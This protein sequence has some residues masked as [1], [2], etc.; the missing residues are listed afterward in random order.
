M[1]LA[2]E[3]S[4]LSIIHLL[5]LLVA[6]IFIALYRKSRKKEQHGKMREF[7]GVELAKSNKILAEIDT[8]LQQIKGLSKRYEGFFERY[9]GLSK[10]VRSIHKQLEDGTRLHDEA[11]NGIIYR[12]LSLRDQIE[13]ERERSL[14]D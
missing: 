8:L 3:I 12:A 9:L 2:L 13:K 7:I 11:I 1:G 5:L 10:E 4:E 6:I 14:G